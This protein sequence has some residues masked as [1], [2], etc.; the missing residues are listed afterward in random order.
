MLRHIFKFIKDSFQKSIWAKNEELYSDFKAIEKVAKHFIEKC[1]SR[2]E[3][4]K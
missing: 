2:K 1:I 3:K 4:E